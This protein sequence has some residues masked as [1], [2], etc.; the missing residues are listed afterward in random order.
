MIKCY[1]VDVKSISSDSSRSSFF[2]AEIEQL[3]DLILAA[4]G[5]LRPLILQESGV[6]KY[7]V[8]EGH[9][10]YYAAV[11]AKEK[12]IKKAEMVNA[13]V[14]DDNLHKSAVEQL[15]L[16]KQPHSSSSV[17]TPT[18]DIHTLTELLSSSIQQLLPVITTAI[19]TQLQPIVVQ[20]TEHQQILDT[21]KLS[22]I[23]KPNLQS[24][25][26]SEA[27]DILPLPIAVVEP[28]KQPE[29]QELKPAKAIKATP[30]SNKK[31]QA[32][33]IVPLPISKVLE[34]HKQPEPQEIEVV[35]K[36]KSTPKSNKKSQ[37]ADILP[38]SIAGVVESP[39]Q[40]DLPTVKSVKTTKPAETKI[41]PDSL[42]SIDLVKSTNALNLINTL[43]QEQ[44]TMSM[45]RSGVSKA[46]VKLVA[47]II[48]KRD[49]QPQQKFGTWKNIIDIKIGGLTTGRIQ[50]II[51]KLK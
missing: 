38:S 8:I 16:L 2:E 51:N 47:I 22:E 10:E 25:R 45:E 50:E 27:K 37:A 9:Q 4:D 19:S 39:K 48:A 32:E 7:T 43:T 11:R 1:F 40:P 26:V 41:V 28:P 15:T 42:E 23:A 12:D 49:I 14:I 30:K 33:N 17:V 5:L 34:P 46:V 31:S 18:I 6:G 21:I 35:K 24:D 13:F 36:T 3:A 29:P 44:L 20:L